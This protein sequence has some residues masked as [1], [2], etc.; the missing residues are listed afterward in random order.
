LSGRYEKERPGRHPN[1]IMNEPSFI[2]ESI[3]TTFCPF[4][5]KILRKEF[6]KQARNSFTLPASA[7]QVINGS[8]QIGRFPVYTIEIK[9]NSI[10]YM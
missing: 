8:I 4:V 6:W 9:V 7:C 10:L 2:I 5:K 3:N 1:S